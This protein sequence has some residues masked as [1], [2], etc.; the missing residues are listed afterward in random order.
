LP[1]E[2]GEHQPDVIHI[3]AHG[4]RNELEMANSDGSSVKLTGS[5]LQAFLDIERPPRLVYLN[6]CNSQEI[7]ERLVPTVAMAIGSTAPITN[8]AAQAAALLFYG[9]L[10]D[11]LTVQN[12][13]NASQALIGAVNTSAVRSKLHRADGVDPSRERLYHAP[14]IIARFSDDNCTCHK[15]GHFN[16]EMGMIG[17]PA[18]T[19]QVV[20]IK[21]DQE[22]IDAAEAAEGEVYED[23]VYDREAWLA[24][25]LCKV[26]RKT[27]VR[28]VVW[29]DETDKVRDD[30]RVFATGITGDGQMFSAGS[31]LCAALELYSR[32]KERETKNVLS[33]ISHLRNKDGTLGLL[34]SSK[35]ATKK[36]KK[37]IK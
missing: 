5:K 30:Y 22:S 32:L 26:V 19:L 27:P 24:G 7:A 8:R 20:F 18:N 25:A 37:T 14:R 36:P 29:A 2:I 35:S 11:G 13:F 9:R 28:N 12:A 15:G 3:S 23:Y 34:V 16:V 17:C 4:A 33:A 21:V 10:L 1:L 31:T 6:A